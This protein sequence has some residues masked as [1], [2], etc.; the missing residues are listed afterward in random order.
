MTLPIVVD[1]QVTPEKISDNLAYQHFILVAGPPL[2][3]EST[4]AA[5]ARR[6]LMRQIGLNL[7]DEIAFGSYVKSVK[8]ELTQLTEAKHQTSELGG[9]DTQFFRERER[10]LVSSARAGLQQTLSPAGAARVDAYVTKVV[11]RHI[12]IYGADVQ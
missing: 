1:G 8:A 4:D 11:K 10:E 6:G 9:G 7:S 12:V 5:E 2:G 3:E